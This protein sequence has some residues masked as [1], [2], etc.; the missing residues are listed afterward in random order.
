MSSKFLLLSSREA[1]QLA[2]DEFELIGR[3]KFLNKYFFSKSREY[4]VNNPKS[5]NP[6]DS[7]AIVGA[8]YAYQF[9]NEG[10]LIASDFSG[11]EATV[12]SRLRE[13]GFE[14]LRIGEDWS[15]DEVR[16]TVDAYFEMLILESSQSSFKKSDFNLRLRDKFKVRTKGSIELKFQNI[17]AVLHNLELPYIDG[18]KPRGNSQL[19]LRKVVQEYILKYPSTI[20]KIIDSFEEFTPAKL[21]TFKAVLVDPPP[22]EQ[23]LRSQLVSANLRLPRKIDYA[24]R[25]QLNRNLGRAGEQWVLDFEQQRLNA[26]GLGNLYNQIDWVSDRLGDG[27]GYDILSFT[28]PDSPRYIEVKTTNGSYANPFLISKN[29]V[30]FS[31]Q[32]AD[33]FYIYRVFS[34]RKTPTLFII[35]G[36]ISEKLHLEPIDFRASFKKYI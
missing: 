18:Y 8:A 14:I 28:S 7:K 1:V 31:K 21:Q 24:A 25:D 2:L 33:K 30:E 12:G 17:S 4:L 23:V 11:G 29:E 5:G 10:P 36:D 15:Y 13:L 35:E 20:G 6:A 32:A 27:A 34:F 16:F 26:I 19:L 3:T 22:L 9:P